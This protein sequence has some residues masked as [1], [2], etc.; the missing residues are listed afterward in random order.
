[1]NVFELVAKLSLD[2][3]DFSKSVDDSADKFDT[4]GDAA[5]GVAKGTEKA[6]RALDDMGDSADSAAQSTEK[7]KDAG[8]KTA[9]SA[10][11]LANKIKVV[12]AQY[13]KAQ[14][15]VDELT[16]AFNRSVEETGAASDETA[17]LA[18]EL[19]HAEKEA[20][21]YKTALD[22]VAD[23]AGDTADSTREAGDETED[24]GEKARGAGGGLDGLAGK[25]ALATTAG[26]LLAE[27]VKWALDKIKA[28]AEYVWTLDEATEDY[29]IA[30]GK[31]TT[32][33]GAMG[34]S[35][36]TAK[37]TYKDFY[38][39]LGDTDTAAESS[40]LLAKLAD[41]EE[42][43]T[44]W[45][46]IAAGVTGTF[47]DSLPIN[48]L[49]EAS[50]ET[51]KVGQVTG[52]L[53][54]ALNWAGV[55][56]DAF[57]VALAA[58]TTESERN[59]LILETLNGE[60]SAAAELFETNNAQLLTH[61][62]N[63]L[64]VQESTALLG[65]EIGTFK[66]NILADLAPVFQNAAE[67]GANFVKTISSEYESSGLDEIFS[68]F[69]EYVGNVGKNFNTLV[70]IIS[71]AVFDTLEALLAPVKDVLEIFNL[72]NNSMET[73]V[74]M[75][76][77]VRNALRLINAIGSTVSPFTHTG[78]WKN[79]Y[80]AASNLVGGDSAYRS[81]HADE[82]GTVYDSS[83]GRWVGNGATNVTNNYNMTVN[84]SSVKEI[85]DMARIAQN[86]RVTRRMGVS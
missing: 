40:Q 71:P 2:D 43:L 46:R 51:A 9:N 37:E 68:V 8:E 63:Q 82:Y 74:Q 13:E 6:E 25:M 85:N 65:E 84:A 33:F 75:V 60:Y 62:E 21:T 4:L 54:D 83:T 28:L 7:V 23:A 59:Q 79:A 10:D 35:T 70:E 27:A 42:D 22:K 53:A 56:E 64:M 80:E 67:Q 61:R 69:G 34:Y 57:N 81:R 50:N 39:I 30:Q 77:K 24:L 19:A 66:D 12:Q 16:E 29:R 1:M 18:V 15:R 48:S 32:A 86:Q 72:W 36:E 26:G 38:K 11:T 5:E 58:C 52:V 55:S 17:Q 47:G 76:E 78:A 20:K 45:T 14:K 41:N 44:K 31:L 49:I 3:D 73:T